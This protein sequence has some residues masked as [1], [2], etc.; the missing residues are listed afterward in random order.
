MANKIGKRKLRDT[1]C[2]D[3]NVRNAFE[4]ILFIMFCTSSTGI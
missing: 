3:I 1:A 2:N 4:L